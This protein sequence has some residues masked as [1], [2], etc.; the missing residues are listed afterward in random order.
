MSAKNAELKKTNLKKNYKA[1]CMEPKLTQIYDFKGFKQEGLLIRK[2]MTRELKNEL[3]EVREQL[4]EK[5][6]EI[7]Q[8]KDIMDKDFDKLYE[9]VEIMK[10]MQQ[11][12]DEKM[13]VLINNQKNNKLPF[14]NQAKE[15]QKFWQLGK[16]DKGSQAMITEE[17]D[18]APL[19]CDKNVVPPKP[20]RNPLE[21][22]H[23][24]QSCCEKCLLCAL[25]TNRNQ[26]R[27]PS[28]HAW[29]PF[30]PLSSGAAF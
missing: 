22:L 9:F 15:Q 3:R 17:P 20:T 18:G 27:R 12:M 7:K 5:M 4:T 28:H 13:D 19:A 6:E 16:M 24:C 8:I 2:G 29:V 1:V 11:D 10:E 25:K 30:S 23:P 21:S 26:G 14:Q